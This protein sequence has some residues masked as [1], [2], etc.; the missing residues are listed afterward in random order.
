[1]QRTTQSA[2]PSYSAG[3]G[4]D[5]EPIEDVVDLPNHIEAIHD[6]LVKA[7]ILDDDDYTIIASVDG[8]SVLYDK[9]NPSTEIFIEEM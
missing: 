3:S 8:S 4:L 1:M 2:A 5:L 7:N 9:A 6:I